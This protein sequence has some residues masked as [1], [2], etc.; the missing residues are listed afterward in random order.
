MS[1]EAAKAFMLRRMRGIVLENS[2]GSQ[3]Y[4]CESALAVVVH[5]AAAAGYDFT[6]EEYRTVV[7]EHVEAQLSVGTVVGASDYLLFRHELAEGGDDYLIFRRGA[8]EQDGQMQ[9]GDSFVNLR[10]GT[11]R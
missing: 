6:E 2:P 11:V 4:D 10:G 8:K 1:L 5:Y 3:W 7:T 9:V